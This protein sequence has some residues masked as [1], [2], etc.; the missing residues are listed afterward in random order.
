[1]K[2][3]SVGRWETCWCSNWDIYL[4]KK[5]IITPWHTIVLTDRMLSL[6]LYENMQTEQKRNLKNE[7]GCKFGCVFYVGTN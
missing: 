1:M 3:E 6:L 5:I 7:N 2:A 4:V